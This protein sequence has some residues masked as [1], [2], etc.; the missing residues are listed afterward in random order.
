MIDG[1]QCKINEKTGLPIRMIKGTNPDNFIINRG[2]KGCGHELIPVSN[3]VIP[4]YLRAKYENNLK[5]ETHSVV[6]CV[7]RILESLYEIETSQNIYTIN[8]N[9][10][11]LYTPIRNLSFYKQ[12][13]SSKYLIDASCV[14][15][16]YKEKYVDRVLTENQMDIM[17]DPQNINEDL[18]LKK[19]IVRCI[20]ENYKSLPKEISILKR[21]DSIRNKKNEI[22]QICHSAKNILEFCEEKSE[23]NEIFLFIDKIITFINHDKLNHDFNIDLQIIQI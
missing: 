18:L 20:I 8:H 9:Y 6:Q 10:N 11:D 2:G 5:Y 3:V 22:I 1:H 21:K 14:M 7:K 15:Q 4:K 12:L 13:N 19:S 17:I 16:E 23:L